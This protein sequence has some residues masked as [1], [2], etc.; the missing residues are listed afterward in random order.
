MT[1]DPAPQITPE[2]MPA[3]FVGH[4]SPTN[5]LEHN[6]YTEAWA[7]VG[8]CVPRPSAILAISAHW[9]VHLSA[10]TAMEVPP[11][12]HDFYGFGEDLF[13]FDYPA[14]GSPELAEQVVELTRPGHVGLDR[15]SWGLDH[16]T[17]SVL[18]HMFPDAD[19]PVVQLSVHAL[20]GVEYHV[21]LGRRLAPL[22]DQGVLIVGSGNV[23]HNL[24]VMD[25][26]LADDG[27]DW[28]RRFDIAVCELLTE[29]PGDI[30][31]LTRHPDWH[32]A[33]PTPEH[34]L[35]LA[36]LAGLADVSGDPLTQFVGGYQ[37]GSLSMAAYELGQ[38]ANPQQTANS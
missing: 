21:E 11:V 26:R 18:A 16:G 22:R 34:F 25:P 36:Y 13:A 14:P 8:G 3:L 24:R 27:T 29:R 12:I 20:E 6:R 5:A 30:A 10:V 35:P 2:R 9:Y 28:N 32:L 23:V 17:W 15:D 4:G 31:E 19:V 38:T 1:R 37:Y 33:A 7:A